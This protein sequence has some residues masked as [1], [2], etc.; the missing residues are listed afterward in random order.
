MFINIVKFAQNYSPPFYTEMRKEHGLIVRGLLPTASCKPTTLTVFVQKI[1]GCNGDERYE[2]IIPA[3][4]LA[5]VDQFEEQLIRFLSSNRIVDK[6]DFVRGVPERILCIEDEGWYTQNG[7]NPHYYLWSQINRGAKLGN[8]L[9]DSAAFVR[10]GS[11]V[12]GK[13]PS[14][15]QLVST[16]S[17]VPDECCPRCKKRLGRI[18]KIRDSAAKHLHL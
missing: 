7:G 4:S 8:P 11:T 16:P 15:L 6:F 3:S 14:E 9:C 1:A 5:E 12:W 2:V 13:Y 17:D 18:G 10:F